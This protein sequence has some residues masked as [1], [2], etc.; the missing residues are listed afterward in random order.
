MTLFALRRHVL[1]EARLPQSAAELTPKYLPM[2][3]R[4]PFSGEPLRFNL[5]RGLIYSVGTDLKDEGGRLTM[6]PL[7]DATE[8]TLETGIGVAASVSP[9]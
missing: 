3:I 6:P 5:L 4:D 8:P 2:P 9:R 7:S 1:V